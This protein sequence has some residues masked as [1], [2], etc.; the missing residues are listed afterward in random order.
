MRS[1]V[2]LKQW[3]G[4]S[5]THAKRLFRVM[6]FKRGLL[7]LRAV[8]NILLVLLR[9]LALVSRRDVR[10]GIARTHDR[11]QIVAVGAITHFHALPGLTP[12]EDV[13]PHDGQNPT[14]IFHFDRGKQLRRI[15][16]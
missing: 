11:V 16:M 12:D 9:H 14:G 4:A 1:P 2:D 10:A 13:S 5:K 3:S 7:S 8:G 15:G 6:D